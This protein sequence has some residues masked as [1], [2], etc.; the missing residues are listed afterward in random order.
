M[1]QVKV[2]R[3]QL[4]PART[5]V[6]TYCF[7]NPQASQRIAH[8]ACQAKD[9][10]GLATLIGESRWQ[11]RPL[12]YVTFQQTAS[13]ISTES[14]EG[15][16]FDDPASLAS[17]VFKGMQDLFGFERNEFGVCCSQ[18]SKLTVVS[19]QFQ[20]TNTH[21]HLQHFIDAN[22]WHSVSPEE[23]IYISIINPDHVSRLALKL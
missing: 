19:I 15:I 3:T 7:I 9:E 20:S 12:E 11:W 2:F 21:E 16:S 23:A 5:L 18:P 8:S 17:C 6:F 1:V 4:A 13:Y 10:R 14:N 22:D